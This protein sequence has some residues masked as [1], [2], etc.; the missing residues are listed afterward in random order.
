MEYFSSVRLF[1]NKKKIVDKDKK[2]LGQKITIE[3]RKN[4]ITKPFGV[5]S[6]DMYYNAENVPQFDYVS[7]LIDLLVETKKLEVSGSYI[8]YGDK[9][10]YKSQLVKKITDECAY[11]ELSNLL[12]A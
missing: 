11:D 8:Q 2:Y 3:A 6:V 12:K 5:C 4:K 7:S 10:Y 9:K 1:L